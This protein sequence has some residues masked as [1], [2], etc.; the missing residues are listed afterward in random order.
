MSQYNYI[1][2]NNTKKKF[3]IFSNNGI[4]ILKKYV[5]TYKKYGGANLNNKEYKIVTHDQILI[6]NLSKKFVKIF[7]LINIQTKEYNDDDDNVDDD[8]DVDDND[9]DDVDDKIYIYGITGRELE[10]VFSY[11]DNDGNFTED[12]LIRLN[13]ENIYN[14][15]KDKLLEYWKSKLYL[16]STLFYLQLRDKKLNKIIKIVWNNLIK[17]Y[18]KNYF[19]KIRNVIRKNRTKKSERIYTTEKLSQK[20]QQIKASIHEVVPGTTDFS[21][22]NYNNNTQYINNRIVVGS[23]L[24][25]FIDRFNVGDNPILYYK[26]EK[27]NKYNLIFVAKILVTLYNDKFIDYDSFID[28]WNKFYINLP[29][30]I[31]TKIDIDK[32]IGNKYRISKIKHLTRKVKQDFN[33]TLGFY[34][35]HNGKFMQDIDIF[36]ENHNGIKSNI[37]IYYDSPNMKNNLRTKVNVM[38]LRRNWEGPRKTYDS[39]NEQSKTKFIKERLIKTIHNVD[40][41]NI[42]FARIFKLLK[43]IIKNILGKTDD[44]HNSMLDYQ[45]FKIA[46]IPFGGGVKFYPI[47][48]FNIHELET[49]DL[50]CS[51]DRFKKEFKEKSGVDF[52]NDTDD[53]TRWIREA[54]G[55]HLSQY[56]EG[57]VYIP[58]TIQNNNYFDRR[59]PN[60]NTNRPMISEELAKL[61]SDGTLH[62]VI[63]RDPLNT[64]HRR[65]ESNQDSPLVD[66]LLSSYPNAVYN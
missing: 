10:K 33:N 54:T 60:F 24:I 7:N 52:E 12:G 8:D 38:S 25:T 56:T 50:R 31:I 14:D 51:Y 15:D 22:I 47:S 49:N 37:K 4:S 9:D 32:K 29:N 36:M 28:L 66:Y 5:E 26:W 3:N 48:L 62:I 35:E 55:L 40:W 13:Y 42:C 17:F 27:I 44:N 2:D 20:L 34:T 6:K 21:F 16:I 30:H 53:P 19:S 65:F 59:V 1:I 64:E 11:F 57:L 58:W 45:Q 41:S 63:F 39:N 23:N 46:F 18:P 43:P 61:I